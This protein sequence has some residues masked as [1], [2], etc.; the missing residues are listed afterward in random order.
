[1]KY[2]HYCPSP[3]PG[4]RHY[5]V[6]FKVIGSESESDIGKTSV[7]ACS[8]KHAM[9]L[10]EKEFQS[11]NKKVKTLRAWFQDDGFPTE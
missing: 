1:M 5:I 7:M 2:N 11:Y 6:E 8:K 9:C 3:V 10:V 4:C